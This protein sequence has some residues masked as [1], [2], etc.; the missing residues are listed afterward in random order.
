MTSA[1]SNDDTTREDTARLGKRKRKR[2]RANDALRSELEAFKRDTEKRVRGLEA[3]VRETEARVEVAETQRDAMRA[4]L[5]EMRRT[6]EK[7]VKATRFGFS[8]LPLDVIASHVLPFLPDPVD[9]ARFRAVSRKMRAAVAATK[10]TIK[11]SNDDEAVENG[12]LSTLKHMH[13]RGR[14]SYKI[15]LCAAA[16]RS[17]QLEELKSL[18]AEK[19]PWNAWT[20]AYAAENGHLETLKWAR[21]NDCPWTDETRQLAKLKWPEVFA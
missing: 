5:E 20:C 9:V 2:E 16:A 10:R 15:H 21:A 18:R 11:E 8:S 12:Y 14:L 6:L 4:E 7:E 17:G 1:T 13:S 19:W 3:R